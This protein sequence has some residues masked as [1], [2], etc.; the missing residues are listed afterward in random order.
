MTDDLSEHDFKRLVAEVLAEFALDYEI[1]RLSAVDTLDRWNIVFN[2]RYERR[3]REKSALVVGP[4]NHATRDR[5][6]ARLT[7]E[8]LKWSCSSS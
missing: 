3:V 8:L 1:E 5:V 6:K 4:I 2:D 7:E